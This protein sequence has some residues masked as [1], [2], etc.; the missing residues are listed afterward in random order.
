MMKRIS[1]NT[2]SVLIV[3]FS[4]WFSILPA[5]LYFS[6]VGASD[7]N[8]VSSIENTDEEYSALSLDKHEKV[9][10]LPS[11]LKRMVMDFLFLAQGSS[12]FFQRQASVTIPLIL[13]C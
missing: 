10:E 9:A 8:S 2:S 3:F 6:T 4:F 7:I 1:S 5:Y 11:L 13:R 12:L